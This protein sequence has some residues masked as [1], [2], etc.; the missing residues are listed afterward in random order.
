MEPMRQ[1]ATQTAVQATTAEPSDL[2]RLLGRDRLNPYEPRTHDEAWR[3]A[4]IVA[5]SAL[6]KL[7]GSPEAAYVILMT[8]KDL[9]L[10]QSQALRGIK[11]VNGAP[12]P[13]ADTLVAVCLQSGICEYFEEVTTNDAQ[14]TWR[15][16]RKGRPERSAT[17]T[18]ED[19]KAAGV[20]NRKDSPWMT[21]PRRMLMARAKAFL[22][23]DV[24]PDVTLG[25]MTPEELVA[26]RPEVEVPAAL[27]DVATWQA[28][29]TQAPQETPAPPPT[30]PPTLDWRARIRTAA[31][32]EEAVAAGRDAAK[33]DPN[34]REEALALVKELHP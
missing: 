24:F 2:E 12:A 1:T 3:L 34:V 7:G 26:D 6:Y 21:Y 33:A 18:M 30:P 19:A 8:G 25:L 27:A 9:G 15:T 13:S 14:S 22:A 29:A 32:R 20:F 10:S 16:K 28:T 5:S 31:T 11:I 4:N 17:F 23:R